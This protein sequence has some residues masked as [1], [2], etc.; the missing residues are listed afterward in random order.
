VIEPGLYEQLL[1]EALRSEL[2]SLDGRFNTS[3]RSLHTAEAVRR[4]REHFEA[5][6]A[7]IEPDPVS[8]ADRPPVWS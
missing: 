4:N 5:Y 3:S 8:G 1:T 7:R 2:D 6:V